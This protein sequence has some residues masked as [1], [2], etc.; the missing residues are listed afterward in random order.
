MENVYDGE[1]GKGE[2][3]A[4]RVVPRTRLGLVA[5]LM[6]EL[7]DQAGGM[8]LDMAVGDKRD[9]SDEVILDVVVIVVLDTGGGL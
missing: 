2:G 6:E 5:A 7:L 8:V 9:S 3:E 1:L 4:I